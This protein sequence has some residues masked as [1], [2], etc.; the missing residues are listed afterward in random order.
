MEETVLAG[1]YALEGVLGEGGMC[2]VYLARD[3]RIPKKW[4]VKRL[5]AQG[6][7]AASESLRAE[8][9]LLSP[10][11]HPCLPRVVDFFTDDGDEYLVMD[12]CEGQTLA[13]MLKDGALG[14][15]E[16]FDITEQLA[17]VLHYLHTRPTPIIYRDLKPENIIVSDSGV[18]KLIDFGIARR[19]KA[20]AKNDTQALGT[21]GYAAPEQYGRGQSD[22]RTDIYG[23]A[24]TLYHALSGRHPSQSPFSFPPIT[25]ICPDF[26]LALERFLNTSLAMNPDERFATVRE[27]RE[28]LSG[29]KK[30]AD[31]RALFGLAPKG[32]SPGPVGD[33]D[34]LS[35]A[36]LSLQ[37]AL[38]ERQMAVAD[39]ERQV[40]E[41]RDSL[42]EAKAALAEAQK[43]ARTE[44]ARRSVE[45]RAQENAFEKTRRQLETRLQEMKE[46]LGEKQ[47]LEEEFSQ[48]S[49]RTRSMEVDLL[50]YE[51]HFKRASAQCNGMIAERDGIISDLRKRYG[52]L[53]THYDVLSKQYQ[54]TQEGIMEMAR[55]KP[56]FEG[57]RQRIV[58][59]EVEV[60]ALHKNEVK[61][62]K[63]VS[64]AL[65]QLKL[66]REE[67]NEVLA[68]SQVDKAEPQDSA[69]RPDDQTGQNHKL[70]HMLEV[71]CELWLGAEKRIALART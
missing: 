30:R 14:A 23:L 67:A 55:G 65:A 48:M 17:D 15:K 54:K 61:L 8:S 9:E 69:P 52:E 29:L 45:L 7:E 56:E 40:A 10:L 46:E 49:A 59:L 36:E 68:S 62:K 33:L 39:L 5:S 70:E 28:A 18:V 24:A 21:P 64:A 57:A 16:S 31:C 53:Q 20:E 63:Q 32:Q 25:Q 26:P 19:H 4:A 42:A 71:C 34:H 27:F 3:L 47:R 58:E 37:V 22:M 60:R 50:N 41:H 12:H 44:A 6:R 38:E 13:A 43:L 11:H 35:E 1:R 2:Q 66:V 51:G